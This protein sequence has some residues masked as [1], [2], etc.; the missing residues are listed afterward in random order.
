LIERIRIEERAIVDE[1]LEIAHQ[2]NDFLR[3]ACGGVYTTRPI[4]GPQRR[5]R[6]LPKARLVLFQFGAVPCE[7]VV[8]EVRRLLPATA[9]YPAR[10]ACRSERPPWRPGRSHERRGGGRNSS[11]CVVTMFSM[12]ELSFASWRLERIDEHALVRD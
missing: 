4:V 9:S 1:P 7:D 12:A 2:H 11:S 8:G 5:A 6:K 10:S 3:V